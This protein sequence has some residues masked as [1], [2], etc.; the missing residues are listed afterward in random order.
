MCVRRLILH[1]LLDGH[2][3]KQNLSVGFSA[4]KS[5][6]IEGV[7]WI[8]LTNDIVV[9]YVNMEEESGTPVMIYFQL[10]ECQKLLGD[11]QEDG[12]SEL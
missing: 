1:H 10:N 9:D 7:H 11:C 8:A 4:Y 6:S 5:S 12:L 3:L 2:Q